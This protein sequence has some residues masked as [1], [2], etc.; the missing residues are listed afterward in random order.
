M[1][2]PDFLENRLPFDENRFLTGYRLW[3]HY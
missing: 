2:K 1:W 3:R